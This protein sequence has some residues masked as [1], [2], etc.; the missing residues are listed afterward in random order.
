MFFLLK[1]YVKVFV[2]MTWSNF[3]LQWDELSKLL[4]GGELDNF[5]LA[6]LADVL[7]Q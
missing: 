3:D 5:D 2:V 7:F 6:T 4:Y 1:F